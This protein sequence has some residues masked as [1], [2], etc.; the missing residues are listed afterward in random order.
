[1]IRPVRAVMFDADGVLFESFESNILLLQRDLRATG[2]TARCARGDLSISYARAM[3][4]N[5]ARGITRSCSKDPRHRAQARSATILRFAAAAILGLRPFMLEL[6]RRYRLALATN[7]SAT[8]PA[9][10]E[11]LKQASSVRSRARSTRHRRNRRPAITSTYAWSARMRRRQPSMSVTAP[12]IARLQKPR[13]WRSWP[14]SA[15]RRKPSHRVF[16]RT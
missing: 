15:R 1:M 13:V 10:V 14:L 2:G 5:C 11:H 12:S 6:K 9:L 16:A 4:S 3:S 8:V 7:R